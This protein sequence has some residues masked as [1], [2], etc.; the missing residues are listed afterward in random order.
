MSEGA[1]RDEHARAVALEA[2]Y[3]QTIEEFFVAR[4]GPPLTI[5][6]A[7]WT[8][9]RRWH[10]A[11]IPL[12]VVLRGIADALDAHA[13]SFSRERPV[14]S[15]RYCEAEVAA[16]HERWQRALSG[17][18]P[19]GV[20]VGAALE[21]LAEACRAAAL[22]EAAR[23][24][25]ARLGESVD[26]LVAELRAR[27]ASPAARLDLE[28]WL[29]EQERALVKLLKRAC[30]PEELARVEA[31]ID[32]D[33]ASYVTRLPEPVLKQVRADSIA[34]RLLDEHGLPRLS[35]FTT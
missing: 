14:G 28:T 4:R 22:G 33:L 2:A 1:Q 15:L 11:G 29:I 10:R 24:W 6:N 27:A 16:A 13:H 34:R 9:V 19:S 3:Y 5:A 26:A 25:P 8:L 21:A 20:D 12:R 7:D 31:E 30:G 35:L 18:G 17:A 32:A 23:A